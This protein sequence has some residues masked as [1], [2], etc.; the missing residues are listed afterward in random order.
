MNEC[1]IV[2][3][4]V[5]NSKQKRALASFLTKEKTLFEGKTA[6]SKWGCDE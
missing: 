2:E 6:Y 5:T 4:L 3:V 1:L